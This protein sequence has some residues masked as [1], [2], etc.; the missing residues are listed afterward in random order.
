MGNKVV[1]ERLKM[2]VCEAGRLDLAERLRYR[3]GRD[4]IS[5][6]I[7][8]SG[9]RLPRRELEP[10]DYE[11]LNKGVKLVKPDWTQED[12]FRPVDDE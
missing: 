3:D 11:V 6:I 1:Y 10:D 9:G 7:E 5:Y 8:A 12:L 2:A 4:T